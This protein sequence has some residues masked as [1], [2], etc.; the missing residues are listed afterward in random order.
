MNVLLCIFE[1]LLVSEQM[2]TLPLPYPNKLIQL[3]TSY[4]YSWVRG[5]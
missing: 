1:S 5:G 4:G 3:I 2:R